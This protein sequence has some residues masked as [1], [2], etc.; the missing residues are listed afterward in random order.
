MT[1]QHRANLARDYI[2]TRLNIRHLRTIATTSGIRIPRHNRAAPYRDALRNRTPQEINIPERIAILFPVS[3][4][5]LREIG[6]VIE[7]AQ[8]RRRQNTRT[9]RN[10]QQQ[11][12]PRQPRR[13]YRQVVLIQNQ[14][15]NQQNNQQNNNQPNIAL[16]R[17]QNPR[18]Y[19]QISQATNFN[20]AQTTVH[21]D[22]EDIPI[23][24]FGNTYHRWL[25]GIRIPGR[26]L[27][28]IITL[29]VELINGIIGGNFNMHFTSDSWLQAG[30]TDA[31]A[32]QR[33]VA[34]NFLRY[35][36]IGLCSTHKHLF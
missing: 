5:H 22:P 36:R 30:E 35:A 31:T 6:Y 21:T 26:R 9:R 4:D 28:L 16:Q 24:F 34:N 23:D 7:Q 15:N 25:N 12:Q 13:R 20:P 1:Q 27:H 3:I 19:A 33:F 14:P 18:T 11:Q 10:Q 8:G 17:N 32:E 2:L 29:C